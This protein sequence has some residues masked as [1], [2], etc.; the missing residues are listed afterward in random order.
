MASL[1]V[2]YLE[3]EPDCSSV[4]LYPVL[5]LQ[6]RRRLLFP[7]K[8]LNDSRL[9]NDET[10]H[11]D[12]GSFVL[13]FA[14]DIDPVHS[15]DLDRAGME[16]VLRLEVS[17]NL[18]VNHSRRE[19][20]EKARKCSPCTLIEYL[21]FE[22]HQINTGLLADAPGYSVDER[23]VRVLAT[24]LAGPS[25]PAKGDVLNRKKSAFQGVELLFCDIGE[26]WPFQIHQEDC[27][28]SWGEHLTKGEKVQ[29]QACSLQAFGDFC[30]CRMV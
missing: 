19:S 8:G 22:R 18:V 28:L 20:L 5:R 9:V 30:N 24:D 2:C 3:V 1:G 14:V 7:V 15:A 23:V 25:D 27:R 26:K 21:Q 17:I 4:H 13:K 29:V 16:S 12:F 6:D 10:L 11:S